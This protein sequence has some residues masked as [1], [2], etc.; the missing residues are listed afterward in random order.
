MT[1]TLLSRRQI[2]KAMSAAAG[3]SLVPKL[4]FA[5][6]GPLKFAV[7]I[8]LTGGGSLYGPTM[9]KTAQ[10]IVDEVNRAGGVLG[11]SVELIVQDDQT[12]P[13]S[14]VRTASRL[15]D[16]DRV[17]AIVGLWSSGVTSAV[18]PLAWQGKTVIA[19]ESGADSITQLPHQGY[20]FRTQ[21]V[22]ALQGKKMAQFALSLGA[23]RGVYLGPQSPFTQA[24][25]VHVGENFKQGGGT[26][27]ESVVYEEKKT[28][29]R[30]ELDQALRNGPDVLMLGG[31]VAD[32][33]VLMKDIYR[34]GFAGKVVST[35]FGVNQQLLDAVAAN[36]VEGVYTTAPSP[37]IDSPA[38]KRLGQLLGSPTFDTY[39]CQVYDQVNLCLL[40]AAYA[41]QTSGTAIRDSIR[42]I[43]A[44]SGQPVSDAVSG[45]KLI[46]AGKAVSYTGASGP[47]KFDQKGDILDCKFRSDRVVTGK[48]QL[49]KIA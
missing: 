38:Y 30:A 35:G 11:Q 13:E 10:A 1:H 14:A 22:T 2:L 6:T 40:A 16:V 8:P 47:C 24:M 26:S 21:P 34:T 15:I 19:C 3:A 29:Y 27:F 41:K 45:L 12:N 23:K 44:T 25:I 31:F 46:A 49:L 36:V 42:S 5:Q 43:A 33:A 28:S 4:A 37:E 17:S 18:A 32:T 20:V 7:L 39:S 48:L 9:Q